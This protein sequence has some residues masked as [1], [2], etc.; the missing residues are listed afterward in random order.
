[1]S[2]PWLPS[3]SS[4]YL[5]DRGEERAAV[6]ADRGARQYHQVQSISTECGV[7]RAVLP[8]DPGQLHGYAGHGDVFEGARVLVGCGRYGEAAL[9]RRLGDDPDLARPQ[10][11]ARVDQLGLAA[12]V[13]VAELADAD[14]LQ[15]AEPGGQAQRCSAAVPPGTV[16]TGGAAEMP[17][18]DRY[19]DSG[20][21][22]APGPVTQ[23][24]Q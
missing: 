13:G 20:D 1:M 19:L 9:V 8:V 16:V 17:Q 22:G 14:K 15:A 10:A 5:R 18:P 2:R 12:P 24:C 3:Q 11:P 4:Q 6:E 21:L 7:E 23:F